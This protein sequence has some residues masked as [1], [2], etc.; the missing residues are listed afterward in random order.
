MP[1]GSPC[2][3][4]Y[5]RFD[6]FKKLQENESG[7]ADAEGNLTLV[8]SVQKRLNLNLEYVVDNFIYI[9]QSVGGARATAEARQTFNLISNEVNTQNPLH[10]LATK[11]IDLLKVESGLADAQGNFSLI[12]GYVRSGQIGLRNGVN[13]FNTVLALEGGSGA[14]PEAR[15]SFNMLLGQKNKYPLKDLLSSYKLL[16]RSES[17][18]DDAVGNF[19]LVLSA[20]EKCGSL[21]RATD[22]FIQ[23]LNQVG[24]S[25]A[26]A[27][28]RSLYK[29]LY[30]I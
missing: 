14:T 15:S 17:G 25:G 18:M 23:V 8:E 7:I 27:E 26:T 4:F 22:D 9:Q 29:R 11:I 19:A 28:A 20:A 30:G 13:F 5:N 24:G 12:M 10:E 21:E 2:R 1:E 3:D 16:L 6:A